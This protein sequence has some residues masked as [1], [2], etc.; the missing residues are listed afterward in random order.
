MT[1]SDRMYLEFRVCL[2][3]CAFISISKLNSGASR[4]HVPVGVIIWEGVI[5]TLRPERR[6]SR[7][8]PKLTL[9]QLVCGH[10]CNL[11]QFK[12]SWIQSLLLQP[13]ALLMTVQNCKLCWYLLYF[14]WFDV[15]LLPLALDQTATPVVNKASLNVEG[16]QL[17]E[18]GTE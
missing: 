1:V 7:F 4:V 12:T 8:A 15:D 3:A 13:S 18:L 5:T 10:R 9:R 17:L 6:R 2:T 14:V 16:E 11:A